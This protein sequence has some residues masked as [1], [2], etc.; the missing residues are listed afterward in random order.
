MSQNVDIVLEGFRRFEARDFDRA[1]PL[2]HPDSRITGPE[3]W[4][5]PGPFEGQDAVIGQFQRLAADWD[6]NRVTDVDVI[7]DRDDW[8]VLSFR[9]EVRGAGSGVATESQMAGAYRLEG[10]R[11]VEAHFRWTLEEALEA[12]GLP[13][14]Q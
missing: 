12:A 1:R 10:G 4:P 8:V 5:E 9:W 2:W 7:V 14:E 6:E 11:M 13:M 3:G